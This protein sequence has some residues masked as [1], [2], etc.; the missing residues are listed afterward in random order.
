VIIA[1]KVHVQLLK[2]RFL[3]LQKNE[4]ENNSFSLFSCVYIFLSLSLSLSARTGGI[5]RK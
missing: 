5:I 4:N 3:A 1:P 2:Q